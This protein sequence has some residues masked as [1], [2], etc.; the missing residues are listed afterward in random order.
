MNSR[1]QAL[2]KNTLAGL[3]TLIVAESLRQPLVLQVEDIHWLDTDSLQFLYHF[4]QR[5]SISGVNYPIAVIL[6]ARLEPV[7]AR[8]GK[9]QG[10]L[11]DEVVYQEI[12]LEQFSRGDLAILAEDVLGAPASPS[13]LGLI[14]GHTGGNPFFAEQI[15]LY[16]QDQGCWFAETLD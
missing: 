5:L 6:T 1:P 13:L 11:G 10:L 8:P 14:E 9:G 7:I 12:I 4:T 2:P 15:L 3:E 16:F